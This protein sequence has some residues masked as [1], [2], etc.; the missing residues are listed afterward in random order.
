MVTLLFHILSTVPYSLRTLVSKRL[1][2]REKRQ[3]TELFLVRISCIRTSV[4]LRTQS[5]YR[6]IRTRNNSSPNTGKYGPEITLYFG[7]F[8][9]SV[10]NR[11]I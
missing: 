2:L 4:N 11:K 3:N 1:P 9:R 6:K 10:R 7:H 5:E 8:S